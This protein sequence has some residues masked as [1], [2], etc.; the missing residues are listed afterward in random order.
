M[1][2]VFVWIG[3]TA[4]LLATLFWLNNIK[5][6]YEIFQVDTQPNWEA[7][8]YAE[9]YPYKSPN[10]QFTVLLPTLPQRVTEQV[11]D[12]ETLAVRQYDMYASQAFNGTTFL[13]SLVH[14]PATTNAATFA[15]LTQSF[16]QDMV[17]SN[18]K[19]VLKTTRSIEYHHSPATRFQIENDL[20]DIDGVT[21]LINETLYVLSA[22]YPKGLQSEQD[23]DYFLQSFKLLNDSPVINSANK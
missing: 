8:R 2:K 9:W 13:V 1:Q 22:I 18:P 7:D 17:K 20:M 15:S 21:F 10:D 3:L 6:S 12:G 5:R 14:F 16:V 4:F 11:K 19:N 23:F